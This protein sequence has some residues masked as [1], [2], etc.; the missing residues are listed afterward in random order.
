[1]IP[2]Y[3]VQNLLQHPPVHLDEVRHQTNE[4]DLKAHDGQDGSQDE[5]LNV[6]A[7]LT[8]QVKIEKP[9]AQGQSSGDEHA[10]PPS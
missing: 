4:T 10:P 9:Q 6:A 1:M 8:L 5:G 7:A 3:P 2:S